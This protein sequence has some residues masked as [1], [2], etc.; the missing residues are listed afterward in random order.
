MNQIATTE[1]LIEGEFRRDGLLLNHIDGRWVP[2]E[3]EGRRE[4]LDPATGEPLA[5]V[6]VSTAAQAEEALVAA[7]VAQP[8]WAATSVYERAEVFRRAAALIRGRADLLA[9]TMTLEEGKPVPEARAEVIRTAETLEVYAGLLYG[10]IG[11]VQEGHRP[12]E[13]WTFT[14][15]VPLGVV[16]AISPWNFP[17]LLPGAKI[18]AALAMG[19]T[20]VL[21]PAD[22]TPMTMAAF[23]SILVEAGVPPGA[24]NLVLGRGSVLGPAL[25]RPPAAAVT[26]TGGNDAGSSVAQTAV[27]NHMKYQLEL[28][29]NNPVLVLGDADMDLVERELT[30][31]A[32]G[33]T[34]QKCTATRRI[35]VVDEA[36]DEVNRRLQA[37]F[38]AKRLGPGIDPKTHVGPL[39]T[40]QARDEFEASVADAAGDGADVRR[41]GNVPEK[42]F[43]VAPTILVE[44]DHGADYVRRETFGPMVSLMRVADY[45]E[46]IE[47]CN[48]TAFGLSASLFSRET[49]AAIEFAHDIEAGMVHI[50]SQT[51]GAEPNMPFGGTKASSSF[52]R[53]MGQYGLDFYTQLKSIYVEG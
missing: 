39:V 27:A 35:F 28:G 3:G 16:V 43:Y 13:Q 26:F 2:G 49:R 7:H 14:R 20:V 33:S 30:M 32:I 40:A 5:E 23:V 48:D 1:G 9:T 38:S 52:S 25:L 12:T 51:P 44:P 18:S 34:G 31:G 36:F 37:A 53:E 19:N 46:G 41:F 50:N 22:P 17:M 8:A 29:G 10:P 21:K 4:N 11:E 47:R 15:R 24:V 45:A 6:A 42:G